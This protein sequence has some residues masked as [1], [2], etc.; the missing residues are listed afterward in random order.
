MSQGA[1]KMGPGGM[2]RG[3]KKLMRLEFFHDFSQAMASTLEPR[4][5]L[6]RI[7]EAAVTLT[8]ATS[9]SLLLRDR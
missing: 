4:R 6:N 1:R 2:V 8:R 3:E 5:L 7:L 9:G